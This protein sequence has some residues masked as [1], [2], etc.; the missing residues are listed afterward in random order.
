ME[1]YFT[2]NRIVA[3]PAEL[4]PARLHNINFDVCKFYTSIS[5]H[6]LVKALDYAAK[7]TTVTLQDRQIIMHTKKSLLYHGNSPWEKNKLNNQFDVTTGSYDG[8]KT[9]ELIGAL[10]LAITNRGEA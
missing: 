10:I 8:A 4:C 1:K 5:Q 9:C 7:F 6:L 3:N 2:R